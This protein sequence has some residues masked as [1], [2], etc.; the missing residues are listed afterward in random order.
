MNCPEDPQ[1]DNDFMYVSNTWKII[2]LIGLC[3]QALTVIVGTIIVFCCYRRNLRPNFVTVIWV[4]IIAALLSVATEAVF[5]R[6]TN[7]AYN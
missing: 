6:L 5:L 1:S 4:L 7:Q 2:T 3:I